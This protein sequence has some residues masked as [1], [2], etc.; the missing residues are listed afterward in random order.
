MTPKW[1]TGALVWPSSIKIPIEYEDGHEDGH[2]ATFVGLAIFEGDPQP[3]PSSFE[4]GQRFQILAI[5]DQPFL[6]Q[7]LSRCCCPKVANVEHR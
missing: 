6:A 1:A 3:W 4:G 7:P 2:V 5:F